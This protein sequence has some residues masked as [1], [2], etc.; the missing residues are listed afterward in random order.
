MKTKLTIEHGMHELLVEFEF[1]YEPYDPGVRY[2]PDGSG[3]PPS[4]DYVDV[5]NARVLC[6]DD[7]ITREWMEVRGWDVEQLD[8]LIYDLAAD[9]QR[10][11]MI[12]D[13]LYDYA[14]ED[15]EPDYG[16]EHDEGP[17]YDDADWE[18]VMGRHNHEFDE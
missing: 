9:S 10:G 7:E 12:Y 15:C 1:D 5:T 11:D 16:P 6:I 8:A 2:Y 3:C 17:D 14:C 4:G 18:A 13:A